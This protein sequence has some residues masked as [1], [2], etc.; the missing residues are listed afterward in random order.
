MTM[1]ENDLRSILFARSKKCI[2]LSNGLLSDGDYYIAGSAIASNRINDID[3]YPVEDKPFNIPSNNR[4]ISTKNAVT[5]SNG[6]NPAI[7]FCNYKKSSLFSLIESFDFAHLQ[8]GAQIQDGEVLKVEW[9]NAFLYSRASGTSM[10]TGSD[11]PLSSAIRL[12]K[13]YK[14]EE[15][16]DTSAMV[17]MLRIVHDIVRHGF[18]GYEDF[19]DQLD[20]VD[21]GLIP[22][23]IDSISDNLNYLI[24]LFNMLDKSQ[25]VEITHETN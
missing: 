14:R 6:S 4:I 25:E 21:L 5:V 22:E 3:V 15:L 19:K 24:D 23:E 13:Y 1:N 7:Q 10:F 8:A 16:S 9:T 18:S 11:Y 12:L 20:A 17:A 2:V